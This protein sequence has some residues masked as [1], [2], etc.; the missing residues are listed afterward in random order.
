VL[1]KDGVGRLAELKLWRSRGEHLT[2]FGLIRFR[3]ALA[4][5]ADPRA[6]NSLPSCLRRELKVDAQL[7]LTPIK[8]DRFRCNGW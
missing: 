4:L 7:P 2:Y 1:L 5:P 8:T 3:A 6:D